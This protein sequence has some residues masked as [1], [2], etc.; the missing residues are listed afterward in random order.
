MLLDLR[1]MRGSDDRVDRSCPAAAFAIRPS[2]EYAVADEVALAFRVRKDGDKYRVVGRVR[3]TLRLSCC[4]CLE[5]FEVPSDIGVDLLYLPQS[6]NQGEGE[7]EVSYEDLSTAFYRDEQI[8]LGQMVREQF[9]LALPMKPLC[10]ADCR[11]LCPVC[12]TNLNREPCTCETSWSD[13][14]LAVLE[15]LRSERRRS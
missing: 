6:A 7:S 3:A 5:P 2:D 4:R 13:P 12:G 8:D 11:G 1:E 10:Q 15:S 14:R 9:E